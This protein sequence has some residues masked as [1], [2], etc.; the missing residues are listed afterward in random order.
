MDLYGRVLEEHIDYAAKS[1]RN[2]A[3]NPKKRYRKWDE[4]TPYSI[5]PIWC[6]ITILTETDLDKDTR[7]KGV[8][9]LLYHDIEEDTEADIPS[10]LPEEV[11]SLIKRMKFPGGTQQEREEL[12]E[13]PDLI[14]L[15]KL[16]DKVSNMLDGIW[17]NER[18]DANFKEY[19]KPMV[20][21]LIEDVRENYG[22]LNIVKIAEKLTE[23]D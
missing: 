14:R 16:Y 4:E 12:M 2:K 7:K 10:Y 11:K 19:I 6:A 23:E 22:E 15:F 21:R 18:E 1:H 8:I 9:T 13:E 5:H 17:Y 20:N 3:N